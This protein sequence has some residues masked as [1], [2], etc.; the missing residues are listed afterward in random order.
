MAPHVRWVH[1]S[2]RPLLRDYCDEYLESSDQGSEKLRTKLIEKVCTELRALASDNNIPITVELDKVFKFL[3][4][5]T[6]R[7]M[8]Y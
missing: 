2:F 6:M 5:N 7:Q 3:E 1:D 8:T 4:L